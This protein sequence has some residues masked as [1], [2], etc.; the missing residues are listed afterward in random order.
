MLESGAD[1]AQALGSA[2]HL[3]PAILF[4]PADFKSDDVLSLLAGIF[5][6][7]MRLREQVGL[8]LAIS[9]HGALL[10]SQSRISPDII[11]HHADMPHIAAIVHLHVQ[12]S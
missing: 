3:V 5:Y 6:A 8:L 10:A 2:R 7:Y 9:V 12:P 1:F 11:H 4:R